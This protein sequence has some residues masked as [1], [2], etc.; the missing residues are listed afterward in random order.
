MN[1]FR[2]KLLLDEQ[3][4]FFDMWLKA[5]SGFS[6]PTRQ[7]I[8]PCHFSSLLP[9]VSLFEINQNTNE[10][11]IIV[12]GSG[13]RDILGEDPKKAFLSDN[14]EGGISA[15][16]EVVQKSFP[17]CGIAKSNE[18]GRSGIVRF[19]MRLPLGTGDNVNGVIGL[20]ISLSGARAPLWALEQMKSSLAS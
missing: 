17:I 14:F 19:W 8:S 18:I 20:D 9:Y 3:R 6:M 2:T 7:A 12:A 16:E 13:L 11:R 10:K 5:C 15:I 4:I 1:R